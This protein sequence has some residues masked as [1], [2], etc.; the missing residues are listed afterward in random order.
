MYPQK[1]FNLDRFK[2]TSQGITEFAQMIEQA[3]PS[4]QRRIIDQ[5]KEQDPEFMYQ[6]MRK[7]IF[8]EEFVYLDEGII[9][10]ILA[11]ISPK[12][13]AYGLYGMP[14]EFRDK[15]LKNLG[16][17]E[18]RLVADEEEKF[19]TGKVS[20]S[21]VLGAQ[22]QIIKQA[23]G[24]EAKNVFTLEISDCPRFRPKKLVKKSA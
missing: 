2:R 23:R 4:Q 16:H 11:V 14:P 3:S 7:V 20:N 8:F 22:R 5:V 9:A 21:Y 17:R 1:K 18:K 6:V 12:L 15:V 10:E 13:L 19:G 24:L